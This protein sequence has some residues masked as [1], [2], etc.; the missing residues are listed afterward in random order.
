MEKG[1]NI[2]MGKMLS[3][4]KGIPDF[5]VSKGDKHFWVEVKSDNDGVRPSQIEWAATYGDYVIIV[6]VVNFRYDDN[7]SKPYIEFYKLDMRKT[8]LKEDEWLI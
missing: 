5:F 6:A 2:V 8:Q 3:D 4:N 7:A 1:F